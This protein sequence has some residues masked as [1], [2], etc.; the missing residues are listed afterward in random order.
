M[1]NTFGQLVHICRN[2]FN[3]MPNWETVQIEITPQFKCYTYLFECMHLFGWIVDRCELLHLKWDFMLQKRS[4]C[5]KLNT[6][7]GHS[8]TFN[9]IQMHVCTLHTFTLIHSLTQWDRKGTCLY[10]VHICTA[11]TY[12]VV[13]IDWSIKFHWKWS[14]GFIRF[15]MYRVVESIWALALLKHNI[16]SF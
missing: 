14:N 10:K 15:H 1:E 13:Q 11:C 4:T 5:L 6:C 3:K 16:L 8:S 2:N 9:I 7:T 12:I